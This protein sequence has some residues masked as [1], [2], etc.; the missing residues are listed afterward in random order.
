VIKVCFAGMPVFTGAQSY[1]VLCPRESSGNALNHG[2]FLDLAAAGSVVI[3][4]G[5]GI[6]LLR[7]P[8]FLSFFSLAHNRRNKMH[9]LFV[10]EMKMLH[11][12]CTKR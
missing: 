2:V 3:Y 10:V 11:L 6:L 12:C 7:M 9:I 5:C 1:A 8:A 4:A